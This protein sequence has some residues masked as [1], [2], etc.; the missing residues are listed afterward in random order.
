MKLLFT[1]LNRSIGFAIMVWLLSVDLS[2][3]QQIPSLKWGEIARKSLVYIEAPEI[4]ENGVKVDGFATGFIVSKQGDLLTAHHAIKGWTK[5]SKTEKQRYPMYGRVGGKNSVQRFP[6]QFIGDDADKD[7]A[8][9]RLNSPESN[10]QPL[11]LCFDLTVPTG[12]PMVALGF[13]Q[14]NF[15]QPVPGTLAGRGGPNATYNAYVDITYAMS[16][17]PVLNNQGVVGLVRG[18]IDEVDAI[19]FVTPVNYSREVVSAAAAITTCQTQI[20]AL[21]KAELEAI[22]QKETALPLSEVNLVLFLNSILSNLSLHNFSFDE[23]KILVAQHARTLNTILAS[24]TTPNAVKSTLKIGDLDHAK[25]LMSQELPNVLGALFVNN[26]DLAGQHSIISGIN[27]LKSD[28]GSALSS[29]KKSI[30]LEP[31]NARYR[32]RAGFVALELGLYNEALTFYAGAV[33]LEATKLGD[34]AERGGVITNNIGYVQAAKGDFVMAEK[35]F[36]EAAMILGKLPNV[37]SSNKSII[38]RNVDLMIAGDREIRSDIGQ[39]RAI[40]E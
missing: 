16:G 31:E 22:I 13:P 29:I 8:L 21:E 20:S 15:Y 4:N 3:A 28:Y 23:L 34:L 6:L 18:G 33:K 39:L 38:D 25:E 9:L 32:S 24:E 7:V 27:M 5:L 37:T 12:T 2:I 11:P 14:G 10:Y 26:S 19:K 40:A 30:D 36:K 17:G 35:S 1:S